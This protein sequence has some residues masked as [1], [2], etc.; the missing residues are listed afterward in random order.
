MKTLSRQ[1]LIFHFKVTAAPECEKV[2]M[3]VVSGASAGEKYVK[4]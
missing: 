4:T 2:S 3:E 1:I